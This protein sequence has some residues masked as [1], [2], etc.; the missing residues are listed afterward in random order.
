PLTLR[1]TELFFKSLRSNK[2]ESLDET[3]RDGTWGN[4]TITFAYVIQ[5]KLDQHRSGVVILKSGRN[6]ISSD[7]APRV[8]ELVRNQP[9]NNDDNTAF[10]N[11]ICKTIPEFGRATVSAS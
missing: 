2:W 1:D 4:Q 3:S 10:D 11:G 5:E 9:D 7:P 6:R 8:V